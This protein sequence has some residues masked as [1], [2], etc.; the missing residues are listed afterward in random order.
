MKTSGRAQLII[1][2]GASCSGK[3]AIGEIIAE[4][5]PK[6]AYISLDSFRKLMKN[7]LVSSFN[8]SVTDESDKTKQTQ[9]EQFKRHRLITFE[10]ALLVADNFLK[11]NINVVMEGLETD[12]MPG[13]SKFRQHF[14]SYRTITVHVDC[15]EETIQKRWEERGCTRYTLDYLHIF[16]K[17]SDKFSCRVDSGKASARENAE[18]ILKKTVN[19]KT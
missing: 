5:L 15:K 9:H 16:R 17:H 2:Y 13:T 14:E 1:L 4:T 7:G 10:N 3:T 6:T 12:Y 18:Y 11:H 19:S 8:F